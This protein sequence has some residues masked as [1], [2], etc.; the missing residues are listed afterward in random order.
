MAQN[1]AALAIDAKFAASVN[2]A[3]RF[4]LNIVQQ[5]TYS[6]TLLAYKKRL[7]TEAGRIFEGATG[8]LSVPIQDFNPTTKRRHLRNIH[9]SVFY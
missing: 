4:P 5:H 6:A 3:A 1:I 9:N 7:D 2:E 8:T